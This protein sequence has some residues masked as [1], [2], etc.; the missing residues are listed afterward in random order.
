MMGEDTDSTYTELAYG[1]SSNSNLSEEECKPR[2]CK[3]KKSQCPK[4]QGG[5]RKQKYDRDDKPKKKMCLHCK[6]FHCKKPHQVELDKCMWNKKY[7][8]YRFK[9]ICNKLKVAFK[10]RHKFAAKLG[11]Y[12]SNG[13]K[14]GDDSRCA[15]MPEDGENDNDKWITVTGKVK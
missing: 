13:N 9:L 6:K 5:R 2:I 12:T 4:L 15:G 7:K 14:S 8:G 11:K 10:P 3:R 1:V